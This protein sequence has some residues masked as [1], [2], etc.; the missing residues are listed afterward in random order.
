MRPV[1][2]LLDDGLRR[3]VLPLLRRETTMKIKWRKPDPRC[4]SWSGALIG[5][6]CQLPSGHAGQH[7]VEVAVTR[8]GMGRVVGRTTTNWGREKKE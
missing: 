4:K 5:Y 3:D 6:R 2:T 1:R 8:N 7:E